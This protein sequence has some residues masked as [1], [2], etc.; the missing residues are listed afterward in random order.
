MLLEQVRR[1]HNGSEQGKNSPGSRRGEEKMKFCVLAVGGVWL[2][3]TFDFK[4]DILLAL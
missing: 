2:T 1:H 3:G 4:C